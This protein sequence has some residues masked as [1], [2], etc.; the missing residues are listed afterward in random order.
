MGAYFCLMLCLLLFCITSSCGVTWK[1][2]FARGCDTLIFLGAEGCLQVTV[3]LLVASS[4]M[5]FVQGHILLKC[6]SNL[7]PPLQQFLCYVSLSAYKLLHPW[8]PQVGRASAHPVLSLHEANSR[9]RPK[10]LW[11]YRLTDD[12]RAGA[13]PKAL[14]PRLWPFT[15]RNFSLITYCSM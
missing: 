15:R 3:A 14:S 12:C 4:N 1:K 2:G 8:F 9:S 13:G 11:S 10:G 6:L 5:G 7:N